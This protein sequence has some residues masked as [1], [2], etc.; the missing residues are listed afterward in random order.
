MKR[1]FLTPYLILIFAISAE[2][3]N[4]TKIIINGTDCRDTGIYKDDLVYPIVFYKLPEDTIAFRVYPM[5][6]SRFPVQLENVA[7][8]SYRIKY[9]DYYG[10]QI[11]KIVSIDASKENYIGLCPD[12]LSEYPQNTLDKLLDGDSV[13][14][15]F[16][17]EGCFLFEQFK[18]VITKK[19]ETIS[20]KIY[21]FPVMPETKED[22][23]STRQRQWKFFKSI[24]LTGQNFADFIRFENELNY[25]TDEGG[26]TTVD[27]YEIESKYLNID[28]K[29]G[30]CKWRGFYFL[31]K[32]FFGE[33]DWRPAFPFL[34]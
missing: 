8:S 10:R 15:N 7:I 20:A 31:R 23:D 14:V 28:R 26:C 9:K 33:M 12:L 4:T 30:G 24:T 6:Y 32:S 22:L 11:N 3:Q 29:D 5:Q 2:S 17:S 19:A 1:I 27:F 21:R 34:Y 16:F 13:L 25:V 18:I